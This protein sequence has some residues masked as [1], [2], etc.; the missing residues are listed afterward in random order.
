MQHAEG[1]L[2]VGRVNNADVVVRPTG[3]LKPLA[4]IFPVE[5]RTGRGAKHRANAD[6]LRQ[7]G[8]KS[9]QQAADLVNAR[10]DDLRH[11]FLVEIDQQ[12][13]R[14]IGL[15]D[16]EI[17]GSRDDVVRDGAVQLLQLGLRHDVDLVG[18]IVSQPP[19]RECLGRVHA[20]DQHRVALQRDPGPRRRSA[21]HDTRRAVADNAAAAV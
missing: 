12:K 14:L 16:D 3:P 5:T 8:L 9:C 15:I 10:S 7:N 2:G 19:E 13:P 20:G 6:Q 17:G 1:T 11:G 4:G 21:G 18:Q